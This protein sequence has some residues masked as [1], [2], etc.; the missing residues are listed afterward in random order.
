MGKNRSQFYNMLNIDCVLWIVRHFS[1]FIEWKL[2][3]GTRIEYKI[4]PYSDRPRSR[5][6]Y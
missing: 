5:I 4:V 1:L 3:D 2:A 6:P